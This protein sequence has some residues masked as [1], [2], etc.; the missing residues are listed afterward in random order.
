MADTLTSNYHWVKPQVGG[1]LA[2]W[3]T[4]INSD[5]DGIDATV[6]ANHT[7]IAGTIVA[8]NAI[9]LNDTAS[10]GNFIEGDVNG[11]A[12]WAIFLGD[13]SPESGANAGSNFAIVS[14]D[15]SG[16]ELDAP[17]AITRSTSQVACSKDLLVGG[18]LEVAG[19]AAIQGDAAIQ[20]VV[21]GAQAYVAS[22]NATAL[23]PGVLQLATGYEIDYSPGGLIFYGGNAEMAEMDVG[24]AFGILGQGY[25]P[26]GGSWGNSSDLRIK[27]VERGY[28]LG[29][30]E[31]LQLNP[32]VYRFRG[33]DAAPGRA[34]KTL[35][36]K[37]KHFVGL[38]AQEAE[39]IF[40]DMV[41]KRAGY[42]D[43]AEVPDFRELDASELVYALV[44]AVKA[45]TKRV[46]EL[47]AR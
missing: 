28:E 32:V 12:R 9:N 31:I 44:N 41:T 16:N 37:D 33:N 25:K 47:E 36:A 45:L 10:G 24:G 35:Q 21:S 17:L 46:Q 20:G 39:K 13:G 5:L 7:A 30:D 38:I 4:K 6:F 14:A 43:G 3:G 11:S 1:D 2:T 15:D 23:S 42:I 29:L 8:P 26:G 40:P 19:G 22:D 34:S 27:T 18:S